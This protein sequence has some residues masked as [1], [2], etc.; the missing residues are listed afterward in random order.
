M[1]PKLHNAWRDPGMTDR[2]GKRDRR[3]DD[4][5]AIGIGTMIVFIAMVI[6]AAVAA[7][8]LISTAGNL[9]RK[10]SETGEETT[11]EVSGNI[12][13][14]DIIGNVSSSG[15]ELTDVYF[16]LGLAPGANDVDL[17]KM[18][19]RWKHGDNLA[20]LQ[21]ATNPTTTD[22]DELSDGFCVTNV[23]N[24][25]DDDTLVISPGDKVRIDV[26]LN[27]TQ[28]ETV[29]NR[30]YVDVLLMPEVGTPISASFDTPA[31]FESRDLYKLK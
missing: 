27:A 16:Y 11:E 7:A 13:V 17:Q 6:V 9:Q 21:N 30:E 26:A 28:G 4:E 8:V 1:Y 20:E 22:C 14:R 25:G 12:F 19:V 10:S 5:G 29:P 3:M 18:V 31:S 2:T 23:I 15:D 24:A